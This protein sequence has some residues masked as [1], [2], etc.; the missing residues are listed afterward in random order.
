M[1]V[2]FDTVRQ[3]MLLALLT[4]LL[5]LLIIV[6]LAGKMPAFGFIGNTPDYDDYRYEQGAV[7]YAEDADS[8]IDIDAFTRIYDSMGDWTGHHLSRPLTEGFLWYWIVCI[9]VYLTKWRW[10]IRI[11]NITLSVF[12][13]K[14]IY[15]LS[16]ILFTKKAAKTASLVY[17]VFPYTVIFSCFSYKD[18]LVEFC[19][20]YIALYFAEAKHEKSY[21]DTDIF[22]LIN[23]KAHSKKDKFCMLLVCAIFILVRSGVSEIFIALCLF[24]YYFEAGQRMPVKRLI[25]IC[26]LL[27]VG[28]VFTFL[29]SN[30]ILYKFNAY[31]GSTTTQ[32]LGGGALVKI[33]GL[34]DIWK[35]LF[36][37]SFSILQPIGFSG[38]IVSW[39]SIVSRLN[40]L[41]CPVAIASLLEII[42]RKR[43]DKKLSFVL[44]LFY[45]IC[46]ASSVLVFRQLYSIWPIPLM[47]ACSYMTSSSIEKKAIVAVSSVVLAVAAVYVLG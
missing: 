34:R 4:R 2:R 29:T 9:L 13:T 32:G 45:L 21:N 27:V 42:F 25:A 15:K 30:L 23:E 3:R 44:L 14:Y 41:M 35:L 5:M 20:F 43:K 47:Y 37:F 11:L 1:I 46:S 6:L 31:I 24:Y 39:L 38:G 16:E 36:T 10:W 19:I 18:T 33:T 17:A 26:G 12:I 22:R 28:I 7:M 40:V 8:L